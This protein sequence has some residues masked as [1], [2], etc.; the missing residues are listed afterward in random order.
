[1]DVPQTE[2]VLGQ[3][4]QKDHARAFGTKTAALPNAEQKRDKSTSLQIG[5]GMLW[6][7]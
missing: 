7:E 2:F 5:P 4:G 1:M 6:K 3:A